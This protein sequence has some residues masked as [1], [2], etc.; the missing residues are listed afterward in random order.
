MRY[1]AFTTESLERFLETDAP[2]RHLLGKH[3]QKTHGRRGPGEPTGHFNK[4]GLFVSNEKSYRGMQI[5]SGLDT[6][7]MDALNEIN[8]TRV[9]STCSGHPELKSG[10][11]SVIGGNDRAG[12][13]AEFNSNDTKQAE[14]VATTLRN[15]GT[16]VRTSYWGGEYGNYLTHIDGKVRPGIPTEVLSFPVSRVTLHVNTD[17][18]NTGRNQAQLHDW[19]DSTIAN[20]ATVMGE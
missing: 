11:L 15:K 8:G 4:D 14:R 16:D 20:F 12:F 18:P 1:E 19:W 6:K 13:N 2:V 5:D 17:F 9:V 10:G 7:Q 3:D